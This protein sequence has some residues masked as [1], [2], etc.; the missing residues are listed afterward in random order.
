MAPKELDFFYEGINS[1]RGL[2]WYQQH[3]QHDNLIQGEVSPNYSKCHLY[4]NVPERIHAVIPGVRIIYVLRE[5]IARIISHFKHTIGEDTEDRTHDQI[6]ENSFDN[7]VSTS[8]YMAQLDQYLQFFDMKQ[9]LIITAERLRNKRQE[10]LKQIFGFL[11]L[12]DSVSSESFKQIRHDSSIK[13]KRN[14]LG[15]AFARYPTLRHIESGIK[16][17]VPRQWYPLFAHVIGSS[18]SRPVLSPKQQAEIIDL[19]RDD[20]Q[21][22]K[23]LT[24]YE[25][26]EWQWPD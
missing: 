1:H 13:V 18:F 20:V 17:I 6:L 11:D 26:E 19:L 22:L 4:R 15:R 3:F 14:L 8:R 9:I 21:R 7:F 2:D 12:D 23:K 16:S 5:P 25:F 24:G 10:T